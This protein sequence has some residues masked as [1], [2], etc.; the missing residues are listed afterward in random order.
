MGDVVGRGIIQT[1]A[2]AS[3]HELDGRRLVIHAD[4]DGL[5]GVCLA[6]VSSAKLWEP[7][8]VGLVN[9]RRSEI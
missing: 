4:V 9:F 3:T 1:R 5:V 6:L 7:V 2:A 8:T